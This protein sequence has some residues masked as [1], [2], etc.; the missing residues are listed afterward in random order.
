M[1]GKRRIGTVS[2][3]EREILDEFADRAVS[4]ECASGADFRLEELEEQEPDIDER[5]GLLDNR[6][7][8]YAL[9]IPDCSRYAL[10]VSLDIGSVEQPWPCTVHGLVSRGNRPCEQARFRATKHF[11]LINPSWEPA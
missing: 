11:Q 4:K 2:R 5:C 3:F 7:E 1:T 9:I 6:H 10:A 8:I